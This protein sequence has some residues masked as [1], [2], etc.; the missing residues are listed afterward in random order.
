MGGRGSTRWGY[1]GDYIPPL[2]THDAIEIRASR[3]F[4]RH[5]PEV[6]R[7]FEGHLDGSSVGPVDF[8][9]DGTCRP[10]TVNLRFSERLRAGGVAIPVDVSFWLIATDATYGGKRW[11]LV[12]PPCGRRCGAIYLVPRGRIRQHGMPMPLPLLHKWRGHLVPRCSLSA[13]SLP[14]G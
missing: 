2:T 9:I 5:P 1:R 8:T 14:P 4:R 12:C 7:S 3:L 6:G 13:E 10:V 11:W